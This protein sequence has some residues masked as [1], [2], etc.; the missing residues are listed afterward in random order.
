[1]SLR[2]PLLIVAVCAQVGL[3]ILDHCQGRWRTGTIS[4][5][6]AACNCLAMGLP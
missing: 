5:L 4:M 6:A 2:T 3:G 1:M